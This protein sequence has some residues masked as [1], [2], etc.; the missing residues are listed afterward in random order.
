MPAV[1]PAP[2]YRPHDLLTVQEAAEEFRT[3]VRHLRYLRTNR[4]VR[5]YKVGNRIKFRW[6][7][8]HDHIESLATPAVGSRR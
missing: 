5:T 6:I 3:T 4:L 8:L 7:D 2:I 1:E